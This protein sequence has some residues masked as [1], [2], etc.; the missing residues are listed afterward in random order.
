[1]KI[2]C[3]KGKSVQNKQGIGCPRH[4]AGFVKEGQCSRRKGP[5]KGRSPAAA[6][7]P[8]SGPGCE[9]WQLPLAAL[10]SFG[11]QCCWGL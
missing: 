7:A 4:A 2:K 1:M 3:P 8:L 10:S 5:G 9:G 11:P 6:H